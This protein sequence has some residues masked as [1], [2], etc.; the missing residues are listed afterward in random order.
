MV[1]TMTATIDELTERIRLRRVLPTPDAA[2]AI[3]KAAGVSLSDVADVLG[4]SR[5]A[6]SYWEQGARAP[7]GRNRDE[8]VRVLRALRQAME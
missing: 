8:Y 4:V 1:G 2:R 7:R 5:Q 3:R 6:V